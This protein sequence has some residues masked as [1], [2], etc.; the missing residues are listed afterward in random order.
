MKLTPKQFDQL[1]R[2]LLNGFNRDELTR[3]VRVG[4]G[5]ILTQI[6]SG[7]TDRALSQSL[8]EWSERMDS[9]P[10]LIAAAVRAN[11][12][13]GQLRQL[14]RDAAGWFGPA[15]NAELVASE[16]VPETRTEPSRKTTL[17]V[18][19]NVPLRRNPNF[20]GRSEQ[21]ASLHGAFN[22]GEPGSSVYVVS[23]LGGV[24]KTQLATEYAYRYSADYDL[25]WWVH[26]E[27]LVSLTADYAGLAAALNLPNAES[28]DQREAVDAVKRWLSSNR[29]WLLV[30]DNATDYATV[31]DYLPAGESGHVF[32]TS[33][34]PNF[35]RLGTT[36]NLP[37][38]PLEE[39]I[40]FLLRRTGQLDEA[41]AMNLAAELGYLPLA[42]EQAGAYMEE[43]GRS[44]AD[45][46][47]LYASR[48]RDLLKRGKPEG[49]YPDTVL[50]TWKIS[51]DE[52]G[53]IA[54]AAEL[55]NLC[56]HMAP[57]SIPLELI[58][59][60]HKTLPDT[61]SPVA[62]DVLSLDKAVAA[63]RR[64]SLVQVED[65]ELN[66]HRLVQDVVRDRLDAA[67]QELWAT[68]SV[69]LV[70]NAFP[71]DSNDVLTWPVCDMLLPHALTAAAHSEGLNIE[72]DATGRLLNQVG[73]YLRGRAQYTEAQVAYKQAIAIGEAANGPDHPIVAVRVSNLGIV[74]RDLGDLDGARQAFERALKIDEAAYG[75]DH[76]I[77]AMRVNNL[78]NI[79]RDLGDL[80]DA[81]QAFERA[82]KIDEAAYGPNHPEVATDT[83]NLGGVLRDL[84]DLDG[85]GHSF[86][87]AL[88]IDEAAFG[89]DHP[90]VARDVNN[91]GG[92]LRDPSDLDDARHAF[93]RALKIDEAAF[94]P[95][96]PNVA[97]DLN[98]LGMVR[99]DL[100]ELEGAKEA[101]ARALAICRK[102]LGDSHPHTQIVRE[103]L[104]SLES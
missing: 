44:L 85:A 47:A 20:T 34:N 99:Q 68:A 65:G 62:A 63:L 13:N 97:R 22:S 3:M 53:K 33:R 72:P 74:L 52:A 5:E 100:G 55:L 64:Y 17:P 48:R 46:L 36:E 104:E 9:V 1:Q 70:N 35:G 57:D 90:N 103:N 58:S 30:L 71:Y 92:V 11:P 18:V 23:G 67:D 89:P 27:E 88:R 50:T 66:V 37:L 76:P 39:A 43:T 95:D 6:A 49:D 84:G 31:R 96:H 102:F 51:F 73:L 77:V 101:Y 54:G 24:G 15:A 83:N 69:R 4:L 2:A 8:I 80:D 14:E 91:L 87:R 75:P 78:G 98:N 10:A 81:R 79:L 41:A 42:L 21:L 82:L 28:V 26:S 29:R 32:V 40:G 45:Y 93:E 12:R 94:G 59:E 25:I 86:E 60:G 19:W 61:L 38:L 56:A 7:D 16:A